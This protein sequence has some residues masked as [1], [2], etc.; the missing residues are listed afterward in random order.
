MRVS[1][2]KTADALSA[3]LA[4]ASRI[5]IAET[6][7]TENREQML[8]VLASLTSNCPGGP[9]LPG[10]FLDAAL[11]DLVDSCKD[12]AEG[13]DLRREAFQNVFA[14]LCESNALMITGITPEQ[15]QAAVSN[16]TPTTPIP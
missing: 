5:D 2:G 3:K 11:A 8:N 4:G 9:V 12:P 6:L 7:R 1:A 14:Q 15:V 13:I 10:W 16:D